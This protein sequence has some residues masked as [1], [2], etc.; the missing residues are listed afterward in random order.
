MITAK[1]SIGTVNAPQRHRNFR[2]WQSTA[3]AGR[4]LLSVR[5]GDKRQWNIIGKAIERP[6]Y[7]LIDG[8]VNPRVRFYNFLYPDASQDPANF[9]DD[10]DLSAQRAVV[11][12]AQE[13]TALKV[14]DFHAEL[15]DR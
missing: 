6:V 1:R 8:L 7:E 9:Y 12:V 14:E 5:E 3:W 10:A 11:Y 15:L 13:F 2:C 4:A